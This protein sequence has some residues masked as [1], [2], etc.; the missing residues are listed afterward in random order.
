[1]GKEWKIG[2]Q[3]ASPPPYFSR[4]NKVILCSQLNYSKRGG[5]GRG[6]IFQKTITPGLFG[7]SEIYWHLFLLFLVSNIKIL[8]IEIGFLKLSLLIVKMGV[9]KN[10]TYFI[11]SWIFLL[12]SRMD[13]T[14]FLHHGPQRGIKIK[15]NIS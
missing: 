14:L 7:I 13:Q 10:N 1:M 9:R 4:K 5:D 11:I 15:V 3:G 8:N 2:H 12:L 6:V